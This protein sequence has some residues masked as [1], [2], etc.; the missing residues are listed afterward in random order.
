MNQ[1]RL[2]LDEDSGDTILVRSLKNRGIDVLTVVDAN[3][4]GYSDEEQLNW[5]IEQERVLYSCNVRDFY[6]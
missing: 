4:K 6:R 3:T 1:I 5:A 2:Y